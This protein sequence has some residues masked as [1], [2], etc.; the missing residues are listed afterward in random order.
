MRNKQDLG[1]ESVA[2]LA[3]AI[4]LLLGFVGS[5]FIVATSCDDPTFPVLAVV[6]VFGFLFVSSF[7][8]L[9][10]KSDGA[11]RV[12]LLTWFK[13]RKP[14]EMPD[15][16]PRRVKTSSRG[17][18]QNAPPSVDDVREIQET[19]SNTWVPSGV[20]NKKH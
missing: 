7:A 11:A 12:G 19:S 13:S 10:V 17:G 5:I 9:R 3:T 8:N 4:V 20:P 18:Q 15:Y 14:A 1:R 6:A 16:S 2:L